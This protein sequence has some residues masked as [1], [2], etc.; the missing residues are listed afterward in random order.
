VGELD[1]AGLL[2][3]H[4][5]KHSV[6][7]AAIGVLR[8]G[9]TRTAY[10]GL[11][12]SGTGEP[13]TCETRF[14]IGSLTKPMVATVLACLAEAGHFSLDDSA[15]THLPELRSAAWAERATM[16]D[17]LANRSRL[18][19]TAEVE[20][21]FSAFEDDDEAVSRLAAKA[22]TGEQTPPCWSYTNA[23][24]CLLGRAIETLT[25]LA[26][27][28]AMQINLLAPAGMDDTTFATKPGAEPRASGHELTV[29]GVVPVEP[30]VS[31]AFGPAGTS[32]LSTVTDMLR[33]A[34]LHLEDPSLAPLRAPQAEIRIHGWLDAWCLGWARFDWNGGP[35][36]GWDGLIAGSAPSYG[37]CR[38]VA[39]RSS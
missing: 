38:S 6:P 17:L 39:G 26:W 19:L 9:T 33:F 5:L 36:W 11:A 1:L 31:Q 30:V 15:A 28:E 20:F 7:G 32:V 29:K 2:G 34:A 35:V 21:S 27:E 16:R 8:D 37:S 13:V 23:G 14:P 18:P 22:A 24:W 12:D 4:A 3:A 10:H 25:G